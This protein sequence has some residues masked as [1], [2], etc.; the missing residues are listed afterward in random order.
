MILY[1]N[2][3]LNI[4]LRIINKRADGYHNLETLF[5]PVFGLCDRLEIT[6]SDTFSFTQGGLVVDCPAEDNLIIR[7]YRRMRERY[8]QIGDVAIA[9]EKHIPF[10]AGLGGGSSDAAHTAIALNELFGLGLSREQLAAEVTPLGADCAFFVYNTPCLAEGIGEIL[11]PVPFKL[12]GFRLVMLK[13]DIHVSTREAYAGIHLSGDQPSLAELVRSHQQSVVSGQQSAVS[14][15]RAAR[16]LLSHGDIIYNDFELSVFPLHPELAAL[17]KRLLDAGA[18]YAAMS[19]S[20][21]TVYG[22]FATDKAGITCADNNTADDL[23]AITIYDGE[24]LSSRV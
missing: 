12:D 5:Y 18:F 14:S 16:E 2:C 10:G 11:T 6:P 4:G 17:K 24:A 13:P 9:F 15:Q 22:L 1:P 8:P 7:C 23:A 20:G 21:S 3:K 19:G